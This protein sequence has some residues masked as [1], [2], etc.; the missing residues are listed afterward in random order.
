[1]YSNELAFTVPQFGTVYVLNPPPQAPPQQALPQAFSVFGDQLK[2]LL[3]LPLPWEEIEMSAED[4]TAWQRHLLMQ[5]QVASNAR[6]AV[7]T[8]QA[9]VKLKGEHRNLRINR[10]VQSWVLRSLAAL[11]KVRLLVGAIIRLHAGS[12]RKSGTC[13]SC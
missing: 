8:L 10:E 1:L 2:V 9:I 3:G 4:R 13:R 5:R 12:A 7:E 11:D 6:E